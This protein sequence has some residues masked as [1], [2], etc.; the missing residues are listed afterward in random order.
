SASSVQMSPRHDIL[1]N[2]YI[3]CP[4]SESWILKRCWREGQWNASV[5]LKTGIDLELG[6]VFCICFPQEK[7]C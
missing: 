3:H 1:I 4:P 2:H 7:K 6:F 5:A